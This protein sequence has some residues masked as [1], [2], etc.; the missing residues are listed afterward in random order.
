MSAVQLRADAIV[1]AVRAHGEH[2]AVVRV[3]TAEH[4]LMAGYVRGA[5]SRQLRPVLIPGNR[6]AA[7]LRGRSA[8][9]LPSLTAE[10]LHSC[11]PLLGEP[12]AALAIGWITA[13]TATVLPE[14][15]RYPR[16]YDALTGLLD[17]IGLAP[18]ARLWAPALV[19][20][21]SL[22]IAELGYAD[23]LAPTTDLSAALQ[24]N[25]S[26]IDAHL[27]HPPRDR[28]LIALRDRLIDRLHRAVA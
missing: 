6:V 28:S 2:G 1:C 10:L 8:E 24:R 15:Q 4:G 11:A 3:M 16:V 7:D 27:L 22:L 5:H 19:R 26:A 23:E 18:A 25:R 21:E 13:L 14:G 12:L 17:A 20:Y 9:Q